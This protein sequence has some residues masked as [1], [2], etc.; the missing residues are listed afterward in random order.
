MLAPDASTPAYVDAPSE[1][2]D[3]AVAVTPGVTDVAVYGGDDQAPPMPHRRAVWV[4]LILAMA[5]FVFACNEGSALGV[6]SVVAE[7]MG[8][9]EAQV[10]LMTTVF[11]VVGLLASIPAAL[12]L[13]RYSRRHALTATVAVLAVGLAVVSTAAS[14]EILLVGRGI[15]ALGHASFWAI[16]TPTVAGLFR[17]AE[18]G[19][20]MT[21]LFM[22]SSAAGILGIPAVTMLA[23]DAG[24][25]L[26]YAVL[27][28]VATL[29][30]VAAFAVIP[31]FRAEQGTAARGI[32]PSWPIFVR[33]L[34]VCLL[35]VASIGV[36]W[37]FITP[38]ALEVAGLSVSALPVLFFVG[39]VTGVI[40]MWL[41]GR[42]LDRYPVRVVAY[43]MAG[44]ITMWV[45]LALFGSVPAVMWF[46]VALQS[47]AWSVLV[48]SMVNWAI[49]HAPGSTDTANGIYA[50]VFNA[51]I[52]LGSLGGAALLASVG[53]AWLPL[54]SL[55]VTVI[56]AGLVWTM[57]GAGVARRAVRVAA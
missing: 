39:G 11:S 41:V 51:G 2:P 31:T 56:A 24:W 20:S 30:A 14:F 13:G 27:A 1:L 4:L 5:A 17:S 12:V 35:A 32:V 34:V 15:T 47:F 43:G 26:P 7:D 48:A 52:T 3:V 16:V 49:R 46:C 10:G 50:T 54:A 9:S 33:I 38:F 22:G 36:T 8:R 40:A 25:R 23:E 55:V 28:V 18:R 57:R 37:T 44:L 29:L 45:L 42:Y 21:K 6:I 53:A 19:R